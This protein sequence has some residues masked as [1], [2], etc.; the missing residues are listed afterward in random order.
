VT[1][2]KPRQQGDIG[3]L[4]AMEWLASR[5]AHIYVPVGHSPDVDLI[6]EIS[7]V[8][9]RVEVKTST[10]RRGDKWVVHI[11]TKGGNQSWNGLVKYFDRS[12]C[13]FLFAHRRQRPALVHPDGS[14]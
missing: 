6:A 11:A 5:G 3:E 10:Q 9:S 1:K 12:R 14:A 4:S 2:L 13:E 8:V 7:G